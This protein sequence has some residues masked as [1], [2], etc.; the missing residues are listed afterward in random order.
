MKSLRLCSSLWTI[1]VSSTRGYYFAAFSS[2]SRSKQNAFGVRAVQ[3]K[4]AATTPATQLQP[5]DALFGKFIIPADSIFYRS[6]GGGTVAFVNL[7]PIVP[8]HVLV[9]PAGNGNST[10]AAHL[11][12]LPTSEYLDLWQTVLHVQSILRQHYVNCTAFNVAVQDGR[13]AGQTV[14][15]V[16]VH[17]LPRTEGDVVRNDDIY[18]QLQEW[19]P[20]PSLTNQQARLEVPNDDNRRDRTREEMATEAALYRMIT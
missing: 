16:H 3:T 6:P 9:M 18:D 8:G 11:A 15:H 17:I 7:R 1:S 4:M 19:A 20:R 12:D 13:A 2:P 14:P 10:G 5:G